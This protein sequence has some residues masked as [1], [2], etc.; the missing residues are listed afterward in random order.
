MKCFMDVEFVGHAART[1]KY[2]THFSNC[3]SFELFLYARSQT[4]GNRHTADV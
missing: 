1:L 2:Q 4:S 3:E